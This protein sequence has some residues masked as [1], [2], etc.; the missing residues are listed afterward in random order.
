MLAHTYG[1]STEESL[2]AID[3]PDFLIDRPEQALDVFD[4]HDVAKARLPTA[5][6]GYLA[7]GTDGNETLV[8]NREAFRNIYL[9]MMRMVDTSSVDLSTVLLDE[10]LRFPIVL[11]P[12]SSQ[13]AFHPDAELASRRT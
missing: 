4:F 5:H 8:A 9:R 13:R 3:L 7:T 2:D 1:V 12:V 10:A 6:Y 11:A